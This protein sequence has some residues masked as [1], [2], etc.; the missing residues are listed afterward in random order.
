MVV[1]FSWPLVALTLYSSG[2]S[3]GDLRLVARN[4]Q[5]SPSLTAGRLEV[6]YDTQWGTVCDNQFG[7]EERDVACR[8][9]GFSAGGLYDTN[10]G[11]TSSTFATR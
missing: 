8:D 2:Q 5:T 9:L 4:G 11:F 1:F 10:V 6:Y 7:T 3:S